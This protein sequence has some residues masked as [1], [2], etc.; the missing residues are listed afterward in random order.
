MRSFL[1]D[2]IKGPQLCLS[3]N[4]LHLIHK[5]VVDH[6]AI[7]IHGQLHHSY[8]FVKLFQELVFVVVMVLLELLIIC[9]AHFGIFIQL[10]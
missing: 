1:L 7:Q 2:D 9:Y 4:F 8:F 6:L 5:L 10:I 3:T